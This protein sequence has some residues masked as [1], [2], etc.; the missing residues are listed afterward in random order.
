MDKKFAVSVFGSGSYGSSL[1]VSIAR[2]GLD[3]MLWGFDGAEIEAI[4]AA[5]RNEKYLPG[6]D[7]PED[8]AEPEYSYLI[9]KFEHSLKQPSPMEETLVGI[10]IVLKLEQY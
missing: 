1:A 2:K 8:I 7:F 6:I 5:G 10:I 9:E 3:V 4:R